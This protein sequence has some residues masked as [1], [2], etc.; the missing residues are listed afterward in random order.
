MNIQEIIALCAFVLAMV[1]ALGA[2]LYT[3]TTT[4]YKITRFIFELRKDVTDIKQSL[5]D[6][7]GLIHALKR[8]VKY[9]N[10]IIT[11]EFPQYFKRDEDKDDESDN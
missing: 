2:F 8:Q 11:I 10:H 4:S 5:Y 7:Q 3:L 9:L 1:S 6:S